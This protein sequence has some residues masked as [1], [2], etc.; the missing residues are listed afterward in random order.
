MLV[1]LD[2]NGE[3][4]SDAALKLHY[5]ETVIIP[6]AVQRLMIVPGDEEIKIILAKVRI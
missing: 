6:N 4:R 1:P 5:A 2:E 3:E